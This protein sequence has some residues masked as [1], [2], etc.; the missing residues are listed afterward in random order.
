M[1]KIYLFLLTAGLL[2]LCCVLWLF[3]P[4]EAEDDLRCFELG[5]DLPLANGKVHFGE[6]VGKSETT[7]CKELGTPEF[8]RQG[9]WGPAICRI[10][11]RQGAVRT[12][13]FRL[14]RKEVQAT[15]LQMI[16]LEQ[17]GAQWSC[18]ASCFCTDGVMF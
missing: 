4:K 10:P 6:H 14:K 5:R 18:F 17:K 9:A 13:G 2:F 12:L 7:I 15:G 16:W 11:V 1:K 3:C 8:D